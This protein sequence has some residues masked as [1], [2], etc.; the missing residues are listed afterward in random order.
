MALDDMSFKRGTATVPRVDNWCVAVVGMHRSGTSATA[1]L[2]ANLGLTGPRPDDVYP[3]SSSNERGHWES[4][5]MV[6]I[7]ELLLRAVDSGRYAPPPVTLEWKGVTGHE[8]IRA[9]A[10]RWFTTNYVGGPMVVKD[11]RFCLTLP[12]WREVLPAP[13]AAVFVLREPLS[14]VR[15]MQARDDFPV[16]FGLALWDRYV[17]SASLV[18]EGLPTLVVEYDSMMAERA[19]AT[20]EIRRFLE[21]VGVRIEPAASDAA[22]RFLDS[23]LHHQHAEFDEYEGISLSQRQVFDVISDLRG[24]HESWT[25]PVLAPEPSW[26][27]DVLTLRRRS[28]IRNRELKNELERLKSTRTY[29]AGAAAKHIGMRAYEFVRRDSTSAAKSVEG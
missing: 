2:L 24:E 16:T 1:G 17:R 4:V 8:E 5:S 15:S 10:L 27:D 22:A 13:M 14:V 11:P 18:L 12:F 23:G 3:T 7:D 20:E 28:L 29:R 21:H 6:R 19:A 25:P 26:V 9:A